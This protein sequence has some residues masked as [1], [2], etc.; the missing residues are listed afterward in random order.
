MMDDVALAYLH[1]LWVDTCRLAC[2]DPT[3]EQQSIAFY[4]DQIARLLIRCASPLPID[5][6]PPVPFESYEWDVHE[7]NPQCY[8]Y[9][10]IDYLRRLLRAMG[11]LQMDLAV[12]V[13]RL[14]GQ[15]P[16]CRMIL[17]AVWLPVA[18]Q[19]APIWTA[20]LQTI[21]P[22]AHS[23]P[24]TLLLT[25]AS[26]LL[27]QFYL[28]RNEEP[29]LLNLWD[30]SPLFHYTAD[31]YDISIRW[32]A[33]RCVC[34]LLKVNDVVDVWKA[35]G[36]EH[37][38]VPWRMHPWDADREVAEYQELYWIGE[39]TVW[40]GEPR[41][42]VPQG[43]T[44]QDDSL[45]SIGPFV[46]WRGA[47]QQRSLELVPTP[48]TMENWE[49]LGAMLA[50]LPHPPPMLLW[51]PPGSGKS[52]LLRQAA[53][54]LTS[55][56]LLEIHV[57]D[58]TDTKT[59]VGSYTST[60]IPGKFE[61]RPGALTRAVRSGQWIVWEDLDRVPIEIQASL[62]QLFKERLLPLG[63][64]K[65]EECHP[66]FCM[67]ATIAAATEEEWSSNRRLLNPLYWAPVAI[68]A[69]ST[70]EL[71]TVSTELYP[72]LPPFVVES[73]LAAFEACSKMPGRVPSERDLF[74]LLGRISRSVIFESATTTFVTEAQRLLCV[75]ETFDAYIASSPVPETR[76]DFCRNVV[77]PIWKV[78]GDQA[79]SHVETRRPDVHVDAV[80]TQIGRA[81]F[82]VPNSSVDRSGS[83]TF[84]QTGYAL[85]LMEAVAVCVRE[86]EPVLLVGETGCGKV[87]YLTDT[88]YWG[89]GNH[90]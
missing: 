89:Q 56:P 75:A 48:T 77:A 26:W 59:L 73:A 21:E 10:R 74:K 72:S 34:I 25:Q 33:V 68:H 87:R 70:E 84:A 44:P 14:E 2:V 71:R 23:Y 85:R 40:K 28:D 35:H 12:R 63:N 50:L 57:D 69:L 38:A 82:S 55:Q 64:G 46:F 80:Y 36:V 88:P 31:S 7:E 13:T 24:D 76:K 41:F 51:G 19:T 16:A 45:L 53:Q 22:Y 18:P 86:N 20:Y 43:W 15:D 9:R 62:A 3:G 5:H 37:E 11:P 78:S 81:R 17:A 61:W 39:T 49:R 65:T 90:L 47:A 79:W 32:Y 52:T 58:D 30:W 66:N 8:Q 1:R 6:L 60:E 54:L 4:L 29:T 67:F 27:V 42:A 83:R